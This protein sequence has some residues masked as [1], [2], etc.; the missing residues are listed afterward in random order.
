MQ[1]KQ[2]REGLGLQT[3]MLLTKL[4]FVL[5]GMVLLA[6]CGS[7]ATATSS[8]TST[9]EQAVTHNAQAWRYVNSG[10]LSPYGVDQTA[11]FRKELRAF[12]ISSQEGLDD[13]EQSVDMKRSMG[14]PIS[15]ARADF[16]KS[17]L[18]ATYYLWRPLQG[19]PLSVAGFSLESHRADIFL[20][21]EESPQGK[22][23]PYMFAPMTMV[24]VDRSHFPVGEPVDFVFHLNGEPL[25]KVVATVE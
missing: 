7:V 2:R 6:A 4:C 18:L 24:A 22:K 8:P 23:Y 10:W 9:P 21:L 14:T 16:S 19:D 12:V 17:I 20:D 3:T 13:F 25:A 1:H 11:A 5:I 15:L